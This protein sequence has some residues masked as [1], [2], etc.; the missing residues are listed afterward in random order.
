[1]DKDPLGHLWRLVAGTGGTG[2]CLVGFVVDKDPL[3]HLWRLVAG[4]GGPEPGLV[5]FVVDEDP[6]VQLW[7][8]VAGTG[9]LRP[10]LRFLRV[11]RF[12]LPSIPPTAPHSSSICIIRGRYK[13]HLMV[14][15]IAD[16]VSLQRKK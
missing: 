3:E 11:L 7:R 9:G 6:F 10:G 13:R 5:G 14:S 15:I 16:S 8:L 4:T 1:M 2:P 12:P